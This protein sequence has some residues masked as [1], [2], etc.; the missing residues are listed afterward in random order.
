MTQFYRYRSTFGVTLWIEDLGNDT[1]RLGELSLTELAEHLQVGTSSITLDD[2]DADLGHAGDAIRG[3]QRFDMVETDEDANNERVWFGYIGQREYRRG[4]TD[5]P[6][7]RTSTARQITLSLV[8]LN[9][10]PSFAIFPNDYTAA[11]RSAETVDARMAWLLATPHFAGNVY[12]NGL[13]ESNTTVMS[14]AD[15]RGQTAANVIGDMEIA[16]GFGWNAFMLFWEPTQQHTLAFFNANTST[17]YSSTLRISNDLADIDTTTAATFLTGTTF[18][19][20][21][22]ATLT[23]DPGEVVSRLYLAWDEGTVYRQRAATE[24]IFGRRD[25]TAPNT[26]I[27]TAAKA[28]DVADDF[29]FQHST[30]TDNISVK[31]EVPTSKVNHIKAGQRLQVKFTHL[32]GYESFTWCRVIRRTVIQEQATDRYILDLDLSPQEAADTSSTCVDLYTNTPSDTYYALGGSGTIP[33][34]SDGVV[35]YWR[36]GLVYPSAGAGAL[37]GGWHF[38]Q[39]GAGGA[40]GG[41]DYAGDCSQNRL[42]FILVGNGTAEIHTSAYYTGNRNLH[43]FQNGTLVQYGTSGETFTVVIDDR[44]DGDCVTEIMITDHSICGGKWGFSHMIWTAA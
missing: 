18:A 35:Y 12:D 24:A 4:D 3:L 38:P 31:I 41:P 26:N 42:I 22:D 19:A 8:D 39:Y 43:V 16:A 36:A 44:T 10:I 14:A 21:Y 34:V 1:V 2:P 27:K 20:N 17:L 33:N 28:E 40:G 5:R 37:Q 25:L 30:E 7:L 11:N 29:L 23:R 15:Y 9:C 32:P 6:S 13:I